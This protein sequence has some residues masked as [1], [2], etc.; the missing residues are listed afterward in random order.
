MYES[1]PEKFESEVNINNN[2]TWILGFWLK[3]YIV[4][5]AQVSK[6]SGMYVW[7]VDAVISAAA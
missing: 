2:F 4:T 6:T 3:I 1:E 5:D 7:A